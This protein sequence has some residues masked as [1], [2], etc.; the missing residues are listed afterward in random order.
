MKI[1]F[2]GTGEACDPRH[3]NTSILVDTGADLHLLDCGFS[4]TQFVMSKYQ[5]KNRLKSVWLSH[6]H[7]DHFFGLPQLLLFLHQIQRDEPLTI[8]SGILAKDKVEQTLEL[9]YPSIFPKLCFPL[10][11]KKVDQNG[12]TEHANLLWQATPT[13][14]S[15]HSFGLRI[16]HQ[17]KKLYYSGDG[18]ATQDARKL[19]SDCDLVIHEAFSLNNSLEYHGSIEECV[20]LASTL[21]LNQLALIHMATETR[22]AQQEIETLIGNNSSQQVFIAQDGATIV[23]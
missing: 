21:D 6:F 12:P 4:T 15:Q 5:H 16:E 19:M 17:K 7:G 8:L 22:L 9:S 2:L 11:Y 23:L 20:K 13:T 10:L 3:P 14:H 18:K 1:T